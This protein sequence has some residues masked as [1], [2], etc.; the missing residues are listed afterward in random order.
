MQNRT[1]TIIKPNAVA[2]G[3]TGKIIDRLIDAGFNI[4][5]MRMLTL[6]RSDAERFYA[7]HRERPFFD[8]LIEFMT[9]GRIV[10]MELSLGDSDAIG[11]LRTLVGGTDPAKAAPGTIRALYGRDVTQN[12]IHASDSPENA[13]AESSQFFPR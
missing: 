8:E 13:E 3:N 5:F 9:S 11:R 7:I 6:T 10:V 2:D 4:D 12:A 1:F